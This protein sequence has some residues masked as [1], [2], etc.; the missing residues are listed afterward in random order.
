MQEAQSLLI[1]SVKS[2]FALLMMDLGLNVVSVKLCYLP[3]SWTGI[4]RLPAR[5]ASVIT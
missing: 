3:H 2:P 5:T 4:S 1:F